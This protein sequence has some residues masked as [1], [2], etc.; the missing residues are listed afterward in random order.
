VLHYADVGD[1]DR[2]SY[3]AVPVTTPLRTLTDCIEA[4]VSPD[5]VRQ[6]VAQA[7]RRGLI[8]E[9]DEVRLSERVGKVETLTR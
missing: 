9:A 8:S 1:D 6:A 4:N 5:L 2:T 3:S 7:R